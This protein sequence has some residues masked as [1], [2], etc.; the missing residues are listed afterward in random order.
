MVIL[1]REDG[2]PN[3]LYKVI[4]EWIYEHVL[5]MYKEVI[6]KGSLDKNKGEIQFLP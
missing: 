3:E 6:V 1:Q 4:I 5:E 2:I